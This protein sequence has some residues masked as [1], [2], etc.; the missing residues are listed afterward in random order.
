MTT[1]Y[2]SLGSNLGSREAHLKRA[3]ERLHSPELSVVRISPIYEAAPR[4]LPDQPWFLNLVLEAETSLDPRRLLE[5]T[6]EAE[7]ALGRKQTVPKG[8][9]T[10]DI[11]ILLYGA[12]IVD[13]EDLKIPH[14]AM[15]QRR[16][17]LEPLADLAPDLCHPAGGR[18]F[19]DSL[20]ATLDQPA[21]KTA[22]S[23][24]PP[25]PKKGTA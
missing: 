20:A 17:V 12:S 4:D 9:R 11:D 10:I 14:P 8:P 15:T 21:R 19:R 13:Q 22:F 16:F 2:L 24:R 18:P 3:V 5:R 7:R 25:P 1:V 23:I 6:Q